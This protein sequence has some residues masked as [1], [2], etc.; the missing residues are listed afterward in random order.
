MKTF[1]D[2]ALG[3]ARRLGAVTL[4]IAVV[5]MSAAVPAAAHGGTFRVRAASFN[6]RYNSSSETDS[7]N[8]W[9]NR[10][11]DLVSLVKSIA[12]DVVGFQEVRSAQY[13]YLMGR[14]SAYTFVGAYR[15]SVSSA[16][17][18][19]VAFLKDRFAL[20][21]SGT[22]WLS[23]TPNVV[24]SKVWGNGIEN[25]GLPRICTWTLLKDR[26]SG[27]VFCFAS[28]HLDLNAGPRLAG[29][30]LILSL[31]VAK[32]EAVDVP[33]VLV[34]DMN[35]LETEDS[36]LA[37]TA[38]MQDSLLY[39]KTTPL[40]SWRTF[41]GFKWKDSEVSCVD[42]LAN[43]TAAQRSSNTSTLGKRIDY[44]FSSIG[45]GVESF[46]TRNDA[47]PGKS[48]YPS[49]HYP[50]VADLTMPYENSLYIGKVRVKINKDSELAR[51]A[52]GR[53]V[54]TKG[55][56]LPNAD[57]LEFVLPDWVERAAVE[58]GEIVI[59]TKPAPFSLLVR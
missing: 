17:A 37:A 50:V 22:F 41:N 9:G 59:Y 1:I 46:A 21:D 15:D 31:L 48:Y 24:G 5:A 25:S 27:G 7:N 29:I 39:S 30:R 19:P 3:F 44:I 51:I 8:N 52:A 40:G 20:L 6:I 32:Y 26:T 34:G 58:D 2:F 38:A 4:P 56:K 13:D 43:Y 23:A 12:P 16:E 14:L 35:A 11:T 55:A 18:T 10:K 53:Y 42:A 33:V 54:L 47:R 45:T 57:N 36:M 28:T 49:D